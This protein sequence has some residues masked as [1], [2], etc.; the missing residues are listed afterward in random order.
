MAELDRSG[1]AEK[2]KVIKRAVKS[3][4]KLA[5]LP[6]PIDAKKGKTKTTQ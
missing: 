1:A 6:K 4:A 5:M 3:S 2:V